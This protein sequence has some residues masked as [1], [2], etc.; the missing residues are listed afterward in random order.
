MTDLVVIGGGTNGLAAAAL[1][2]KQGKRVIVCEQRDVLGGLAAADTLADGQPA[3]G[4][5]QDTSQLSPAVTEAL[6]LAA[7]GLQL[8][9]RRP[10]VLVLEEGG[11]GIVLSADDART[12]AEIRRLSADDADKWRDY[13]GFVARLAP[14]LDAVFAK[15]PPDPTDTGLSALIEVGKKAVALRRLGKRDMLELLRIAPMCVADYVREWFESDVLQAGLAVPAIS[16]TWLGPWSAGSALNLLLHEHRGRV[17]VRG[18]APAL[19]AA[20]ES[21]ARGAGVHVRTGAGVQSLL[22]EDGRVA[23]VLLAGGEE[24][25][26]PAVLATCDPRRALLDL[27]PRG[28]LSQRLRSRIENF[29][30]R[31]T[32]GVVRIA[33][34]APIEWPGRPGER[35]EYARTSGTIDDLERAFDAVK[36]RS[37]S[38]APMLEIYAPLASGAPAVASLLV[39]FAPH[40]LEGGWTAERASTLGERALAQLEAF[41]PGI[42]K[43]I[44]AHE[45]LTPVDLEERFGTT[46][47]HVH[48]GE[49]ALDQFLLRPTPET[50]RYATPL[51]GY[52]LGG[53]GSHPGGGLTCEP[54]R[55]AAEAIL[56]R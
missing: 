51:A 16:G 29:R 44:T 41:V 10:D 23:G 54:G 15:T 21:A 11:P 27:V 36:Y 48:H 34:S 4:V 32:T 19:A 22:V 25:H 7:H 33:L 24:L 6:D 40:E 55:L 47:G 49:H 9:S 38:D 45:V 17:E 31:G 37:M 53:S 26:A 46:G 30:A 8:T 50:S 39:H 20:L 56:A 2:A 35:I 14:V 12:E 1:C 5:L 28:V 43:P 52:F 3:P 18:G 13:R 42:H